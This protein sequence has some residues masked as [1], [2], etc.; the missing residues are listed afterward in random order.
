ML[1]H[2]GEAIWRLRF[3]AV[4]GHNIGHVEPKTCCQAVSKLST[5]AGSIP[6]HW[7]FWPSW[8]TPSTQACRTDGGKVQFTN[9]RRPHQISKG[10]APPTNS[11][12][13]NNTNINHEFNLPFTYGD[14]IELLLNIMAGIRAPSSSLIL[15]CVFVLLLLYVRPAHAFGAGNIGSTSK[16]EGQNW[17][18]G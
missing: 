12:S 10:A 4:Q 5:N 1:P 13:A 3:S 9:R 6:C 7:F 15:P 2:W 14:K 17:R 16:I 18:H 8:S 11:C